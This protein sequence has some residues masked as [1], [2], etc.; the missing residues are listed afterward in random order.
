LIIDDLNDEDFQTLKNLI[1]RQKQ[2]ISQND[3]L[4]LTVEDRRFHDYLVE[5]SEHTRLT[6]IWYPLMRQWEVLIY[7]RVQNYPYVS[8][9]VLSDHNDL[10]NALEKRDLEGLIILHRDINLRVAREMKAILRELDL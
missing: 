3:N 6:R 8:N 4:K 2:A 1:E 9:T 5:R 10:L 7:L